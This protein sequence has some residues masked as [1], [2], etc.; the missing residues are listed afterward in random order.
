MSYFL[1]FFGQ[2][3]SFLTKWSYFCG[4]FELFVPKSGVAKNVPRGTIVPLF[5]YTYYL[6]SNFICLVGARVVFMVS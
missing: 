4:D 2:N 5:I 3:R 6:F 1:R